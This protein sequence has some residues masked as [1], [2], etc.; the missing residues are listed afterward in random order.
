MQHMGGHDGVVVE[1][2]HHVTGGAHDDLL[3]HQPPR[4]RV[5]RFPG[6]DVAVRCD[7]PDRVD[8]GFKWPWRQRLSTHPARPR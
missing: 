1:D 2:L 4:H 8:H 3:A 5:Q 6:F 7:A